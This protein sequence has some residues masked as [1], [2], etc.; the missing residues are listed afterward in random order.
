MF[1][2]TRDARDCL[3]LAVSR[4]FSKEPERY[5]IQ[6]DEWRSHS[7]VHEVP[8]A[9]G[10]DEK[11]K[12][13]ELLRLWIVDRC[14]AIVLLGG[15]WWRQDPG[16][17]GIPAEFSL[18]RERGLPCFLL[19]GLGGAAAGYREHSPEILRSLKNGFDAQKNLEI[20]TEHRVDALV[21]QVVSQLCHLPL[22]R[23]EAKSGGTFRILALDGGGIKGTFTAAVLGEWE[24]LTK[25]NNRG[26]W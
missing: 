18:A 21:D 16:S 10:A 17:A 1:E 9:T 3:A 25:I 24:A 8:A 14:D 20:A 7:T 19:G 6:L 2:G 26:A 15:K 12:S 13:L 4:Y 23:G 22:V 11:S 5:N